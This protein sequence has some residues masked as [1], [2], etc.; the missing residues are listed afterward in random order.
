MF[1]SRWNQCTFQVIWK[2]CAVE[3]RS[4]K[5]SNRNRVT[6][7]NNLKAASTSTRQVQKM[8]MKSRV[9]LSWTNNLTNFWWYE[10]RVSPLNVC[11]LWCPQPKF[12]IVCFKS[13]C[14]NAI[15]EGCNMAPC[16]LLIDQKAKFRKGLTELAITP[17]LQFRSWWSRH[18]SKA[19]ILS[20]L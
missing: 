4:I 12:S 16:K 8:V 11:S 13:N 19:E 6:E 10:Q 1:L 20:F 18:L 17:E 15:S 14:K 7:T 2:G 5:L 9:L 3:G